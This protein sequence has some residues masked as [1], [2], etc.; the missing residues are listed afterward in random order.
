MNKKMKFRLL[1]IAVV[2]LILFGCSQP[3]TLPRTPTSTTVPTGSLPTAQ[4][5]MTSVPD[6]QATAK[7]YLDDWKAE[8][9]PAMYAML[10]KVSQDAISEADFTARY[11]D[12]ANE[13]ALSGWD[14]EILSSLVNPENGQV[15]YRVILHSVLVGDIDRQTAMNLSLENGTWHIQ[16]DDSLILPELRGGNS[17]LMDYRIPSRGNIYSSDGRALVAQADA[18][19]IGL[20][21]ASVDPNQEEALL[22]EI[23]RLT[24]VQ[25]ETLSAMIE[26]W[27]PYGYYLPVADIS[28]DALAPR[29][30]ALES[31]AGVILSPFRTRYYFDDGIASHVLGYMSL[32]QPDEVDYYRRLGYRV[33]ERVGRDGLEYFAE[34]SLAGVRGGALYVVDPNKNIVTQLAA[35]D[36]Q[37]AEAV[38]TTLD[39][40]LQLGLQRSNALSSDM[41]GAIV[42]LERDT[43]RVL[44]MLSS[45][46]FN[47]NLFEPSNFNYSYMINDLYTASTPLLNRATNGQYPLGSVFKIVTMS[48]ALESGLYTKDTTYECGY[49]F[50]ELTGMEP[51]DWTYDHYLEDGKTQP[52]GLLTLPEGLMRSCN[53]F[54][55]HIGLDFYNRGMYTTISDMARAF[56]L[57]SSTGIEIGDLAGQIP[58]PTSQVDAVNLAIAQGNTLVT[59]LQVADFISAVGNGGTLYTPHVIDKIVPVSGDPT[60]TFAPSV[61][62]TLPVSPENL[63]TVQQ[64]MVSVVM[65][66]RGTAYRTSAYGI[67]S[68]VTNTGIP[69]AAK[70]GTAESGYADPHAW[71]AGYTFA[72]LEN[73]PDI[74]VAVLVENGGEGSVVAEPIFR[75]VLEIY[76]LGSPQMRY[77]WEAQIGVVATPTPEATQTAT[78]EATETPTP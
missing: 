63:S 14:Y 31:Y 69:V 58:D 59:P 39:Y 41:L 72:G 20:D 48:A 7:T 66:P 4:V 50:T 37:P 22:G 57:G 27:R 8:E 11:K 12:A 56:G 49:F 75:R 5:V 45:P 30:A 3:T 65:N 9:Y 38:Y 17:L 70:T 53:P 21:T 42:V 55:W 43:G 46:G 62:G 33:D 18:V 54:F 68:F 10:T 47:P 35:K 36:P 74:A 34:K 1:F 13:A 15:G 76:F 78:P 29:Q 67:N 51:H 73:R 52:S 16:W 32:I 28:V 60:Y 23:H 71:F 77:P 24:G 26:A 40:D 2:V 64:A 19:A 6:L 25:P 61:R 44:A